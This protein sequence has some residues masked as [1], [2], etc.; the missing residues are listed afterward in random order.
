MARRAKF[1]AP[2][3]LRSASRHQNIH[4][5]LDGRGCPD[6]MRKETMARLGVDGRCG[7]SR[8]SDMTNRGAILCNYSS[9]LGA[10]E[11][12]LQRSGGHN[13]TEGV[14]DGGCS[15]HAFKQIILGPGADAG[16]VGNTVAVGNAVAGGAAGR[17]VGRRRLF[18]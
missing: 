15:Q 12:W 16:A 17:R 14:L 6:I 2:K 7:G 1:L 8:L 13:Y 4:G 18:C 10:A 9:A 3:L 5:V 11:D